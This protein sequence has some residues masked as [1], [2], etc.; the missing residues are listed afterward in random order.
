[1]SSAALCTGTCNPVAI[2]VGNGMGAKNGILFKTAV[3]LE[4]TGKMQIIA[5]DKT[6]TITEGQPKVTD[7]VPQTAI[8]T[9]LFFP[10]LTPWRP[11]ANILWQSRVKAGRRNQMEPEAVTDFKALPETGFLLSAPE[12][13][14]YL[15]EEAFPLSAA[16]RPFHKI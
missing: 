3:S 8:Q 13:T 1:M 14:M 16:V 7:I 12:I 2:M 9:A 4:E 10:W 15:P 11:K 6:G 5:L